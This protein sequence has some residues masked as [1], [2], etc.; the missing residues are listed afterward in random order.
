MKP[1]LGSRGGTPFFLP[2][3]T[4]SRSR[5]RL[6][7]EETPA[8]EPAFRG[9]TGEETRRETARGVAPAIDDLAR[10]LV[11]DSFISCQSLRSRE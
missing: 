8:G 4:E 2:F 11:I 7:T 1:T 6:E 5:R 3:S 9:S 10:S